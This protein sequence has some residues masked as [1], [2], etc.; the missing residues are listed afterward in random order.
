MALN[1]Y[2]LHGTPGEQNLVQDLINEHLRMF[3]M[4][5]YYIPRKYLRTDSIIKEVL[6]SKFDDSFIIEAYLNNFEGYSPGNDIMS[7]FGITLKNELSLTISRERFEEFIA[8]ILEG[9]ISGEDSYREGENLIFSTRPK[10]GDIIYFPLGQR[11]FEIKRVEFENPFYQLGRNYIYELQCELFE[12]EDEEID[13]S[14]EEIENTLEDTGYITTLTMVS[15]GSTALAE[16][17]ITNLGSVNRVYLNNDGYGYT[18]SPQ[19]IIEPPGVPGG[20]TATAIAS[21]LSIPGTS[22]KSV[23]EILLTNCGLGYTF[24][25]KITITGGGG[26]GAAA[27]SGITTNSVFRINI[28]NVGSNYFNVPT[29]SI[30]SPIGIGTSAVAKAFIQNGSVSSIALSN[31][32]FGYTFAPNVTISSPPFVGMGTY[33]PTEEIIGQ[34]SGTTGIVKSWVNNRKQGK[35]LKVQLID[36]EFYPGEVVK[37]VSSNAEYLVETFDNNNSSDRYSQ[38]KSIENES[39]LIVDFS[40]SNPFGNY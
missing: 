9:M 5:V 24:T 3:G 28:T 26:T 4:D 21:L 29:V 23:K 6:S 7:K 33:F 8:P 17:Q 14:V 35:V 38:N 30:D 22:L 11:I 16:S 27:T 39:D 32:G 15:L 13:T 25:P 1:P 2:F 37:G 10:E 34:T 40:E 19:V 18:S 12:Y 31:S 36:G 20:R